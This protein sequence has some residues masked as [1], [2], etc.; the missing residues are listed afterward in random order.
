M[1]KNVSVG[2][3]ENLREELKRT[4]E[5][6]NLADQKI[7]DLERMLSETIGELYAMDETV[8]SVSLRETPPQQPPNLIKVDVGKA[9][10]IFFRWVIPIAIL[11]ALLWFSVAVSVQNA[12]LDT[13][14]GWEMPSIALMPTAQACTLFDRIQERRASRVE[15]ADDSSQTAAEEVRDVAVDSAESSPDYS[16][17]GTTSNRR[18]LIKRPLLRNLFNRPCP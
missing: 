10:N 11:L 2:M 8:K 5:A 13:N 7:V 12:A 4:L 9:W 18:H 6:K 17:E 3:L 14:V 16:V 1:E 15:T